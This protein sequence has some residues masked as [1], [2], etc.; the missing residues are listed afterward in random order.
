M[1]VIEWK[2][3]CSITLGMQHRG[4]TSPVGPVGSRPQTSW[5]RRPHGACYVSQLLLCSPKVFVKCG[6]A[7]F[8][9]MGYP[10]QLFES[11]VDLR[12]RAAKP[13]LIW[14]HRSSLAEVWAP[15]HGARISQA[16]LLALL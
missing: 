12:K 3:P 13:T 4:S 14:E 6:T 15:F 9:K 7:A 11:S 5:S 16:G 2:L 1:V 8:R 10:M